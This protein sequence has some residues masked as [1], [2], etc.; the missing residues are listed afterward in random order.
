MRLHRELRAARL[1]RGGLGQAEAAYAAERQ[2]GNKTLLKETSIN[3]WSWT[4][5]DDLSKD[6]RH[7]FRMLAANPLFSLVAVLTLGLGI[8]ANT[9]VFS[10]TNAVLLRGL[11][12]HDPQQLFYLHVEPSQPSGANN[13]GNSNSSF[14]EYVFEQLRT[15]REAFAN[16]LAYVPAGI[17]KVAVRAGA[18]PEEAAVMMVSGDFL[19][20]LGVEA[21]C[22]RT[23]TMADEQ[24]HAA[25][26]V[27][28]YGFWSRRFGRSC[29]ALGSVLYVKGVPFSVVGVSA[30]EFAGV[31]DL[32][33]DVWIPLQKRP[34]LNAWGNEGTNYYGDPKWWCLRLMAR[35]A[36]G[37]TETRAN[38]L[39]DPVF[40]R[41]A[42]EHLGGKPRNGEAPRKLVFVPATGIGDSGGGLKKPLYVLLAMV[43]LI[44]V[45]AC[46]NVAM[47]LAA[48]N[49]AR[50]REFSLR[51]AIGGS[52][53]RLFRQL[54][55][56]SLVLVTSGA[57]L[58]W[59]FALVATKVLAAWANM[60]ISLAPD[61]RVLLFTV[62]IA[63]IAALAFGLAPLFT[64]VRTPLA[65]ALKSSS[66]TAFREKS[67]SRGAR[68]IVALQISL[69]LV[70]I[71]GAGLLASTL[72]NLERESLGLRTS[73]LLVFGLNPE[74]KT[75]SDSE[76]ARF[77]TGLLQKLR[78]LPGVE[79][80]TLM[81]N[82][83]G[84]G[85]SNNTSAI[86]DGRDPRT[87]GAVQSSPLRWNTVGPN[88]FT[89][90]GVP[91]RLGRDFTD[92][93][94]ATAPKVAIVNETFA[95]RFFK[96][97]VPLGHQVSYT[98][99]LAFTIVGVAANSKYTGVRERDA[100]MAYFPYTQVGHIGA[101]HIE[102]RT[103]GQAAAFWPAVRKAVADYAPELPL[104]K[105]VTQQAQ[106]DGSISQERL[107]ARLAVCFGALATLLV[108]TGLY[109]TLAYATRRRTS[110][111]GIRI[112]IGAR[113]RELLLMILRE[114][115]IISAAGIAIG[116]PLTFASTRT[117]A[118]L[119]YG[120]APN[121]PLTLGFSVL[122]IILVS[123]AASLLPAVRAAAIDPV[124]ALR[125]E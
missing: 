99:K 101:L 88:Y 124:V 84:S 41:A 43:G 73:G 115:L 118:S 68:I 58:G 18:S 117:L 47:L 33:I 75:R 89:T 44:L 76:A 52:R 25:V 10:V 61:R 49:A 80:V 82:R 24:Q 71:V 83:I 3:M 113:P 22:G 81:G 6:T 23:L 62:G 86:V 94:S 31:E 123:L 100:P 45:I 19:S 20:G 35:L 104:L 91:V 119:L 116:L 54:L 79:A 8:G 50:Q 96:G 90:L 13:T 26:A 29:S 122:G 72:R 93:D 121:D 12:V 5:L 14:S 109:G 108:I 112:A 2:F 46:G 55:A 4:W 63:V 77:F 106:F 32:A 15:Q 39:A 85:W 9:A 30:R 21:V 98:S 34:E 38:A 11:P 97:R 51:M 42:Y 70:L 111:L 110:E 92:A 28:S 120:L 56:E 37:V 125:Y 65:V 69:C 78:A 67:K 64:T 103:V 48:R 16:L 114:S 60:E 7:T 57:V 74:L 53:A 17:G 107:V 87:D 59:L 1:Q 105:P 102:V 27:V 95:S 40:R 66:A 36:P